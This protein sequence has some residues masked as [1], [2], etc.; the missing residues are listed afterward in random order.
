MNKVPGTAM[1][2]GGGVVR[3]TRWNTE[4]NNTSNLHN[5]MRTHCQFTVKRPAMP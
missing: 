5:P 2:E 1:G 4:S 3:F